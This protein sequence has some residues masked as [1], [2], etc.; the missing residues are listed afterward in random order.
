VTSRPVVLVDAWNVMR[1]R[2]PNIRADRFVEL[3]RDWAEQ[4]GVR[5]VAVFDGSA[6]EEREGIT[7]VG[8]GRESADDWIASYASEQAPDGPR[9]WLVSSD[10]GLRERV[11]G[12]VERVV[13]GG[14]FAGQLEALDREGRRYYRPTGEGEERRHGGDDE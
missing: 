11:A 3:T 12:Q 4:E 14:S 13:G 8:T 7:V 1:S 5:V 2:W 9:L 6:P 10:R